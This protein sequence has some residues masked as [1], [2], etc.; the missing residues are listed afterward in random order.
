MSRVPRSWTA[1]A[2]AKPDEPTKVETTVTTHQATAAGHTV[3]RKATVRKRVVTR[4]PA[5]TVAPSTSTT[6]TTKVTTGT[7]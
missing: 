4:R 1:A 6:T 2:T 3:A 7:M 5:T